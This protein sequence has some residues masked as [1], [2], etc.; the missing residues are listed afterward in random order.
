MML[1]GSSKMVKPT[2]DYQPFDIEIV[3]LEQVL[4]G[5]NFQRNVTQTG[6]YVGQT[7]GMTEK[8][9]LD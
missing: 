4:K 2:H 3:N 5:R 7:G 1:Q 9:R 6:R 8:C